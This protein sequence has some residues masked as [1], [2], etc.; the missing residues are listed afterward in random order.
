MSIVPFFDL[1]GAQAA[2]QKELQI[3][4]ARVI[5][6]GWFI[7]GR[8]LESFERAFADYCGVRHVVGVAS[9]LDALILSLRAWKR[10]GRLKTGDKVVV[11]ANTFIATVMAIIENGLTPVLVEPNPETL[12][13]SVEGVLSA[14]PQGPKAVVAVHLYGRLCPMPELLALCAREG[15]LLL[16]DAAQA[17]G[18]LLDNRR[19]GSFGDA[20]GF[21]FYPTKNLGALGDGGAVATSDDALAALLRS[22]RNYGSDTKYV[23]DEQGLNSRLDEMQAAL[24]RVKL[25]GLDAANAA[26]RRIAERYLAGMTNPLA[27]PPKA[28]SDRDSHVWHLFVVRCDVRDALVAHLDAAGIQT[29]IHYPVAPHRQAC[30]RGLL[31]D[32]RLPLTE[33]LQETCLSLPMSPALT[34]AQ[35]DRVIAA[36]NSFNT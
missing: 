5:D 3:A 17:H 14:L 18:A 1:S 21:S 23:N 6:S 9:G 13:L 7:L 22:L 16:E 35:A 20:A 32:Y 27:A 19:A 4:A 36:I 24:L 11:P 34:D 15:L 29:A 28:P 33:R 31:D 12:N 26:R 2:Q 10:M 30:Y 8:E 25:P